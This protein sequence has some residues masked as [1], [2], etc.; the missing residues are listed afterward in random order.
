MTDDPTPKLGTSAPAQEKSTD[1]RP[2]KETTKADT[3]SPNVSFAQLLDENVRSPLTRELVRHG[4][5]TH[6][7]ARYSAKFYDK[8]V[9]LDAADYIARYIE[10]G[11]PEFDYELDTKAV[12][13]ILREQDAQK[14]SAELFDDPSIDNV[15]NVAYL[16]EHRPGAARRVAEHLARW[17]DLERGFVDVFVARSKHGCSLAGLM[18]PSWEQALRYVAV[19]APVDPKVRL[20]LVDAVLGAV[21][22]GERDDLDG[23]VAG[24]LAANYQGL[25][26]IASPADQERAAVAMGVVAASGASLASVVPLTRTAQTAAVRLAVYPVTEGNLTEL[27]PGDSI[28]LDV[29][30]DGRGTRPVYDHAVANLADYLIALEKSGTTTRAVEDPTAFAEI[31]ADVAEAHGP[32]LIGRFVDAT[33]P[34][35]QVRDLDDVPDDAWPV[36]AARGRT[37][38]TRSSVHS[39]RSAGKSPQRSRS[40]SR[41]GW[42]LPLSCSVRARPSR[43]P[44]SGSP[45]PIASPQDRFR[46]PRSSPRTAT[47]SPCSSPRSSWRTT[48]QRSSRG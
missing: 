15:D 36:L 18:A 32:E 46:P 3:S 47:S 21:L 40:Q 5:L 8:D 25:T 1:S 43:T 17:E 9:G 29:L 31:L 33:G 41:T 6:Q 23:E 4:Y 34:G 44:R 39:S 45:S 2:Q 22:A 13:Q 35:C 37:G 14:D 28:A 16:L 12:A 38:S 26:A 11:V 24:Y 7:F 10:P 20:E 27:A 42:R 19:D 30:R 48:S